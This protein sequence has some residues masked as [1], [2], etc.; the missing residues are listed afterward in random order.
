MPAEIIDLIA[1]NIFRR[2]VIRLGDPEELGNAE[3]LA[4]TNPLS[5]ILCIEGVVGR[6]ATSV[7]L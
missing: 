7:M 1:R 5:T 3:L 4:V 2:Q 6:R